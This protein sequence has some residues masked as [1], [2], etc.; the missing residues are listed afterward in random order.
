M[1]DSSVRKASFLHLLILYHFYVFYIFGG[2][3][4]FMMMELPPGANYY[5]GFNNDNASVK[6][7][8]EHFLKNNSCVDKDEFEKAIDVS[9]LQ[10]N[11]I[12]SL[13]ELRLALTCIFTRRKYI[14]PQKSV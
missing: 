1:E 5:E 12:H 3:I 8:K 4:V 13:P 9:W 2:A 14:R 7:M 6:T 11:I 10:F